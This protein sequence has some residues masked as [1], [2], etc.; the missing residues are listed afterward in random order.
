MATPGAQP[1]TQPPTTFWDGLPTGHRVAVFAA[2][3]A[4]LGAAGPVLQG[5]TLSAGIGAAPRSVELYGFHGAGG[6]GIAAALAALLVLLLVKDRQKRSARALTLFLLA[7]TWPFVLVL[8]SGVLL[9]G[10][11]VSGDVQWGP[12]LAVAASLVGAAGALA[13]SR[14]PNQKPTY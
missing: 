2:P 4:A 7:L 11:G 8:S 12:F 3:V 14:D 1:V 10:V 5:T 9:A 13:G 6:V